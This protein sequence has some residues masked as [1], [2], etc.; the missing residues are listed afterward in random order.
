MKGHSCRLTILAARSS[1]RLS[2]KD[3]KRTSENTTTGTPRQNGRVERRS[4][5]IRVGVVVILVVEGVGG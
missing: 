1:G 4:S 3:Q 2:G 5:S